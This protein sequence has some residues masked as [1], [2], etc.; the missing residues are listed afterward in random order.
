MKNP[1]LDI[2]FGDYEGH[3]NSPAVAQLQVLNELFAAVLASH[4][5]KSVAIL[6]CAGGNGLE[7]IDASVTERV[8]GID[9]NPAYLQILRKRFSHS[10]MNLEL[11]EADFA[12]PTFSVPPVEL[13]FAA[14]VFEYVPTDQAVRTVS[15]SLVPDGILVA[16]LQLPSA[17]SPPVT[18]TEFSSLETLAPI[19]ELVSP[20]T[21]TRACAANG[22]EL[23]KEQ[24]IP[25]KQGKKLFA[26]HYRKGRAMPMLTI[27][28]E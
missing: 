21:F 11:V 18:K 12:S 6:G 14:L 15:R 1:W 5:P 7:H 4:R 17:A 20:D 28:V 22:L 2:P 10:Q 23:V 19:L 25:L 3:M 16:A 26:G 27:S 8:V 9:I 13:V 24:T